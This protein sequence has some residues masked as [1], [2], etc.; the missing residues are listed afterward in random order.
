MRP[1]SPATPKAPGPATAPRQPDFDQPW[2][3]TSAQ[4][5][6]RVTCTITNDDIAPDLTLIK[7]VTNDD[8]GDNLAD[9]WTL[10]ASGTGG[11]SGTGTQDAVLNK[12]VLGPTDV[13]ANVAYALS[14]SG[15]SGYSPSAWSCEGSEGIDFD[16]QAGTIELAEGESATCTI[17]NDDIAPTL[18]LVKV[19]NN[20]GGGTATVSDF[21]ITTTA[22]GVVAFGAGVT[23][24]SITTYMS[25][26]FDTFAGTWSLAEKDLPDYAEGTWT[27]TNQDGGALNAGSVTLGL[28]ENVTCTITNLFAKLSVVKSASPAFYSKAGDLISYTVTTTNVGAATLTNVGVNDPLIPQLSSWTCTVDGAAVTLP[29]A[30]LAPGKAIVC[31]AT[32]TVTQAD[33]DNVNKSIPNTACAISAQTSKP[34]CDD[35]RVYESE[36]S[37]V[38]TSNVQTYDAVGDV[39]AY[40]VK[41]TNIGNYPLSNVVVTDK[42]LTVKLDNF[43]CSPT[44]PVASLAPGASITCTGSHTITQ[45]DLDKGDVLNTACADSDQTPEVCDDLDIPAIKLAVVKTADT[46]IAD[47]EGEDVTFTFTVTNTSKIPVSIVSLVDSDFGAL[48]GDADCQ[49]GTSLPAGASCQ[50]EA[51]FFVEPEV[52]ADPPQDTIPH[53]NTFTACAVSGPSQSQSDRVCAQDDEEIGWIGGEGKGGGGGG[54]PPTDTLIPTDSVSAASGPLDGTMNWI[55]LILMSA[56]VILSAGWVIR[57]VRTSEILAS[58]HRDTPDGR[59]PSRDP[60]VG[61]SRLGGRREASRTR[62]F[63]KYYGSSGLSGPVPRAR[64]L[65][66]RLAPLRNRTGPSGTVRGRIA[67]NPSSVRDCWVPTGE[68]HW[69]RARPHLR[70]STAWPPC[71]PSCRSS[72]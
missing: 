61:L 15:P 3:R 52:V 13:D 8:G 36:L 27:C 54:Q 37:I 25:G 1:T 68:P 69:L 34:V 47:I 49:V 19:V 9:E 10:S 66:Y 26:P 50:F 46:P 45:A 64:W 56:T 67:I 40:T 33:V 51:T 7:K 18:T 70:A 16:A 42:L 30:S 35:E 12:A 59:A 20:A 32:Y 4:R 72:C 21:G 41:A 48:K 22:P 11:F 63:G 23:N 58:I 5:R 62:R 29:V 2:P 44:I 14:E 31:K 55:L 17:T 57:R 38:K 65:K 6:A 71:W 28:A 60:A 39:I 24:G 43:V 53:V